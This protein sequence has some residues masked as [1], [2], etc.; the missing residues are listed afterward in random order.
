MN[1]CIEVIQ[2]DLLESLE[3]TV[4]TRS[5]ELVY[6]TTDKNFCWD[7][8]IDGKLYTNVTYVYVLKTVDYNGQSSMFKGSLLVL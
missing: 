5:G 7:G 3:F 1:D 8:R 4:Y 6:R 2:R